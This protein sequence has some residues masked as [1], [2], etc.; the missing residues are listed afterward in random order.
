[1]ESGPSA[2]AELIPRLA[3]PDPTIRN[4]AALDLR[5]LA[6]SGAFVPVAPFLSAISDP[7]HHENRGTLVYALQMM[8]CSGCFA[9]LLDLALHGNYE[10]QNHALAILEEQ[11]MRVTPEV[12]W[13]AEKRVRAFIPPGNMSGEDAELLRAELLV[14]LSRLG[15]GADPEP[16]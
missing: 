14:I 13:E 9:Q 7:A 4:G 15:N 5:D 10:C 1:M 16:K 3:S 11:A 12:L 8:D 6:E 2:L